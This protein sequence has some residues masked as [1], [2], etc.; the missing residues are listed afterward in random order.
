M[1][2]EDFFE[3]LPE[4]AP[5]PPRAAQ[6]EWFGPPTG[7]LPAVLPFARSEMTGCPRL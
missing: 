7:T 1:S 5:E 4:R 2:G 6:P 3:P